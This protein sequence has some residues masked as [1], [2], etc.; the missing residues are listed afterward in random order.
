MKHLPLTI[1][2]LLLITASCKKEEVSNGKPF[3]I[4]SLPDLRLP[5]HDAQWKIHIQGS[6]GENFYSGYEL[7]LN[8]KPYFMSVDTA[9][10][11]YYTITAT[12]K[13][14][15]VN[16]KRYYKYSYNMVNECR[17]CVEKHSDIVTSYSIFL[18]EDS[19]THN[20]YSINSNDPLIDYTKR[21]SGYIDPFLS[22]PDLEIQEPYYLRIGNYKARTWN[23]RNPNDGKEY[24][25]KATGIG[26]F[27][28]ILGW[29]EDWGEGN[30]GVDGH[31]RSFDFRY[32]NDSVHFEYPL[33]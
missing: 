14:T 12:G 24:F 10:Y 26:S 5:T 25:Y 31:M 9:E 21:T 11:Y 32:M 7:W 8:K 3:D 13:D 17:N 6:Y 19:I 18:R 27:L 28:G 2:L 29:H 15:V 23:M 33:N 16:D 4:T 22:W 30:W 1:L 20:L